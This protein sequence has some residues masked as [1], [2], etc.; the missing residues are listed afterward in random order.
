MSDPTSE[1]KVLLEGSRSVAK[2]DDPSRVKRKLFMQLGFG[3][4]RTSATPAMSA[5]GAGRS[6]A[7]T[8]ARD[9]GVLVPAA[10][11]AI[12]ALVGAAI[13]TSA[14]VLHVSIRKTGLPA[15]STPGKTT[16]PT[17]PSTAIEV[18]F[19]SL[20][21]ET[22]PASPAAGPIAAPGPAAL[23]SGALARSREAPLSER[24][25][26]DRAPSAPL[27]PASTSV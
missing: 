18:P 11:L 14:I 24:G 6:A 1:D 27:V 15:A 10:K 16:L 22:E 9:G 17:F 25:V 8:T 2:G 21:S 5:G 7:A 4:G 20:T 13:A 12:A 19:P 3:T 23:R 26:H